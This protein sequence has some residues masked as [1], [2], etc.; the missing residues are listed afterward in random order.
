MSEKRVNCPFC[1]R[2]GKS[3]DVGGHLYVNEQKQVCHCKRCGHSGS[4]KPGDIN[5]VAFYVPSKPKT[6]F[7]KIELFSF[8]VGKKNNNTGMVFEYACSRLPLDVVM[9]K[10]MWSPDMP[11]RLFF[12][13]WNNGHIETWQARS[14]N[15]KKPKYL[16]WGN[17][18]EYVYNASGNLKAHPLCTIIVPT[19]TDKSPWA[20]ILEGPVNALSCPNGIALFGKSL[21]QTQFLTITHLY[22]TIYLALDYG[23]EEEMREIADRL[24][25]YIEVKII[26]F[27]DK[28]DANELGKA[29]MKEKIAAAKPYDEYIQ[30]ED[31]EDEIDGR[32]IDA[33]AEYAS[34]CD[35]CAELTSH[36]ELT[37]DKET[38]LGYCDNCKDEAVRLGLLKEIM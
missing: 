3:A 19:K 4:I 6:N 35:L 29:V 12:P 5:Q 37:G 21:S 36:D 17:V 10:C 22:D 26:T 38:Q 18:S 15:N 34:T 13:T 32:F 28:R 25:P 27:E 33:V 16:S 7:D 1:I 11:G 20:V 2:Y 30:E 14:I 31:R 9:D 24:N 8:R 23:A